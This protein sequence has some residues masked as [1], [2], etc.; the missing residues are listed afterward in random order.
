M[1]RK[2][3]CISNTFRRRAD[4]DT[5]ALETERTVDEGLD[6]KTINSRSVQTFSGIIDLHIQDM[7]EVGQ[8]I[9]RSKSAVLEA[10]IFSGSTNPKTL[11]DQQWLWTGL[12]GVNDAE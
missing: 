6:P 8:T 11:D 12:H 1:R 9:R 7:Q 3:K 10:L 2:G 5:W 4:A